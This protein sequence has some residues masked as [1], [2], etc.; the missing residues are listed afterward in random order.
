[1]K[2]TK[3]PFGRAVPAKPTLAAYGAAQGVLLWAKTPHNHG[4]KNPYGQ[5]HVIQAEFVSAA[6]EGRE[7]S[8]WANSNPCR[9]AEGS[10]PEGWESLSWASR[11]ELM[12]GASIPEPGEG[13]T[14]GPLS[15]EQQP[16]DAE[17][18]DP[19]TW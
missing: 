3:T 10:L 17:A 7:V 2:T 8:T 19:S 6:F 15:G 18:S 5:E 13:L 1:M 4:G 16:V 12:R 9:S 14:R 11:R